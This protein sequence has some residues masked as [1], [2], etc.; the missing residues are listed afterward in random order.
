MPTATETRH[1][2]EYVPPSPGRSQM[3]GNKVV[4]VMNGDRKLYLPLFFLAR[5]AVWAPVPVAPN[6]EHTS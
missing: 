5:L 6:S 1:K 2:V 3:D 4:A